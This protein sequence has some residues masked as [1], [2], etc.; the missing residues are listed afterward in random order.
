[1]NIFLYFHSSL[2]FPR[3]EIEEV[4]EECLADRGEITGGGSGV[5]G[6]NIDIEIFNDE[7]LSIVNQLIN[8]L[9]EM[10][11]PDDTTVVINSKRS[12]LMDL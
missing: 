9:K 2:N 10:H 8:R 12:L 5:R 7:D 6:S 11:L 3:S 1:M 4:L